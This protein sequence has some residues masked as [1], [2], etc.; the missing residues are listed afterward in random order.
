MSDFSSER[1]DANTKRRGRGNGQQ[2]LVRH[3]TVSW[4]QERINSEA[5]SDHEHSDCPENTSLAEE[6]TSV[7]QERDHKHLPAEEGLNGLQDTYHEH[8]PEGKWYIYA[9]T[10]A[11]QIGKDSQTRCLTEPGLSS[12]ILIEVCVGKQTT[13]FVNQPTGLC[14][15][16]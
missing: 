4:H 11:A 7:F 6:G 3:W 10:A 14:C 9:C 12:E 13:P 8:L 16:L 1:W 15:V 2:R 5:I